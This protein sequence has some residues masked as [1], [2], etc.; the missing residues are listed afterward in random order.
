MVIMIK[1][2]EK[3]VKTHNLIKAKQ[4]ITEKNYE[5]PRKKGIISN[6][7]KSTIACNAVYI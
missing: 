1:E 7:N 3:V 4:L 6:Q 2:K 5:V